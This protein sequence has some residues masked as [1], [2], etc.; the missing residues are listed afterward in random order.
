M[1][2]EDLKVDMTEMTPEETQAYLE[3]GTGDVGMDEPTSE[4]LN[5]DFNL[6]DEY[7]PMPLIPGGNYRANVVGVAHEASKYAL[8]FKVCFDQ[9]G[10]VMSDGKTE[11]DG[12]HEYFRLWLPKPGDEHEMQANGK[13]TKRQGKI[14][15]MSSFQNNMKIDM[16]TPTAIAAAIADGIWI[17]IPVI[18]SV[19]IEEYQGVTR[20]R[21][22]K[23][24]RD[25]S[26]A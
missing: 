11:I 12:A 26:R 18:V 15:Q 3:N 23:M 1:S 19:D 10:G 8:A 9:N 25:T 7:K 16:N 5:V 17:G 20:N 24:V 21:L 14:N 4:G 13:V 6:S 2:K 22:T